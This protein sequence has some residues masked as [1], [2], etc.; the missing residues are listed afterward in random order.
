MVLR[1]RHSLL[2]RSPWRVMYAL[3]P[4]QRGL[5]FP[6]AGGQGGLSRQEKMARVSTGLSTQLSALKPLEL[7]KATPGPEIYLR[8]RRGGLT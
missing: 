8:P 3:E 4:T 2:S 5:A 7:D 6:P 1:R